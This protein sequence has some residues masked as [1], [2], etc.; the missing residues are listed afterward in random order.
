MSE[1][2]D[3]NSSL[4]KSN[5]LSLSNKNINNKF[6]LKNIK[7]SKIER[8]NNIKSL[9]TSINEASSSPVLLEKNDNNLNNIHKNDNKKRL[10]ISTYL[11]SSVNNNNN[12]KIIDT[13]EYSAIKTID[14]HCNS[15]LSKINEKIKLKENG[16]NIK[17][18]KNEKNLK[19][20]IA[21]LHYAE[22]A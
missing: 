22:K 12:N 18:V 10:S 2:T 20:I 8:N 3:F 15:L 11:D 17:E 21:K 6:N 9:N 7:H 16:L 19:K 13:Y 5:N 14:K 4:K 1:N